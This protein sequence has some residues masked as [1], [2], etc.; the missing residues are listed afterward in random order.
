MALSLH[1]DRTAPNR[2]LQQEIDHIVN[3]VRFE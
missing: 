3:S 1:I 2:E